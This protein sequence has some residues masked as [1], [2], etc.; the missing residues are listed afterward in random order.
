MP[1]P[2]SIAARPSILLAACALVL[3]VVFSAYP[4]HAQGEETLTSVA[5]AAASPGDKCP[6]ADTAPAPTAVEVE[7]VPIVVESTTN[8]YFVLYARPD[9]DSV[10]QL[11]VAVTLGQAGTTTLAESV[12]ALPKERYRVEKY[13]IANPADIDGDCIDDITELE[14]PTGMNPINPAVG[15]DF[16]EGVVGIPDQATFEALAY[17]KRWLKFILPDLEAERPIVYFVNSNTYHSHHLFLEAIGIGLDAP[18][19]RGHLDYNPDIVS[20]S[21][22]RGSYYFSL[23]FNPP[24]LTFSEVSR[25]YSLIAASMP[26]LD[27]N[28]YLY[29]PNK[30]LPY[31]Q[32]NLPLF[33]ESR[34]DLIFREDVYPGISFLPLNP[35]QGYGLLRALD[36]DER[37]NPRDVVIYE[38]L[39]NDLPRVAGIISVVPQTPLSHVN[40][41]AVQDGVPNAFIRGA[42]DK[43]D[44]DAL[45]GSYVHY[46]VDVDSYSLRAATR[47]EVDAHYAAS[48]PARAQTPRRDLSVTDITP[49]SD[50]E[51][52]DWT[53][54]GVKAANVAVLGTLGFP[55]GTVPDGFAVP[56]YF[57]DEFMKHNGFYDDI[58][59]M[60]ADP[61]FQTDYDTQEA[62]LKKLRKAIK[63]GDVPEWMTAALEEMHATYPEVQS[64]RYRSSTNNEDLPGFNGAGLYDSKT[65]HPDETVE[66]GIAKSLKQ[67]YASLWN[68]RAFTER[69]LHRIDH[70]AAAMGVLVHPNYTGELANGVAVSFDPIYNR[71]G[72]HYVNTQVG[73]DLVTNPDAH[74]VPEEILLLP[75]DTYVILATSNQ[76]EPGQ[77]LMS[78]AQL[79]QLRGH[80]EVIHDRF[81]ELYG[82]KAEE[83]FAMEIEFKITSDDV[84]AIKQARPWVFSDAGSQ[85]G[86]SLATGQPTIS[87][88]ARVGETLTASTE[89]ITDADGLDN[90]TF[91]YQWVR[92]D[93]YA[94]A[95]I[96]DAT[97]STYTLDDADAGQT[98]KVRVSFTDDAGHTETL[99][100]AA[101][102]TVPP[103]AN[104][105]ATGAPAISGTARVGETLTADVSGIED[106]DGL[107]D[108]TF[109]YQWLAGDVELPEATDASYTL[110]EA[111]EGK[112]IKVKVSFTDYWG[113][114][115]T[116]TS[117]ATE[118]AAAAR[119]NNSATGA[120]VISGT[121]HAGQTLMADTSGI[122]DADGLTNVTYDYQWVADDTDI[123]G[124]TDSTYTLAENDVG[125]TLK[126]R[127]SFTDNANNEETLTSAPT[128]AVEARLNT[129]ATGLPAING[130]VQVGETLTV[131][132]SAIA[133]AD[134]LD[135]AVF[136]YQW[137]AGGTDIE[138]ATGSSYTL[139]SSEEGEAIQVRVTYTD[140]VGNRETLTSAAMGT[141]EAAPPTI[142]VTPTIDSLTLDT[143]DPAEIGPPSYAL[144]TVAW[145]APADNGGS[146]ITS[147]DLRVFPRHI[148]SNLPDK[149]AAEWSVLEGIWDSGDLELTLTELVKGVNYEIQVRAVNTSGYGPWSAGARKTF[150]SAPGRIEVLPF[151]DDGAI[152]VTQ[153]KRVDDGG[154]SLT[155]YDVRYIRRD[156]P[157]KADANW[158]LLRNLEPNPIWK[159]LE[160][161]VS[162]L[163]NG[164]WY[165]L[166][167]R[168]VNAVG[169]GPWSETFEQRPAG[170][171]SAPVL[172]QVTGGNRTLTPGWR[173]PT[174][175]GGVGIV[176]YTWCY[177][178]SDAPDKLGRHWTCG[179]YA[180]YGFGPVIDDA[181]LTYT[182]TGLTNNMQYD[183][184][185]F[186]HGYYGDRSPASNM[187]SGTPL[188]T[189]GTP[190]ISG[191]AQVGET[192][193][194]DV[195]GIADADGLDNATFGHQWVS[196]DGSADADI[197]GATASTYTL[198]S[199]DGGKTIKVRVNFTDEAGHEETLTS[200]A[201]DTVAYVPGPP[202]APG[203][204]RIKAGDS[205][206]QVSWQAPAAENKAPVQRYRIQ[207]REEGGSSQEVHTALLTHTLSNLTNGVAYM[208]Q[209]AAEN[210]AG[211]GP[212]SAEMSAIPQAEVAT[213][214]D[215]PQGFSG[216]AVYHRRVSL[217]W[218]D[219]FGA[220]SYEVQFYDW[221]TRS[222]VVL[223]HEDITVAF[224]GSSAV[225]D[226]LTGTSLWWLRVRAVN[227]AGASEWTEM[228]QLIATKASDWETEE[229][230]SPATG[231][232]TISGTAQVGETLTADTSGI[233]DTEGL[234]KATFT[235]QWLADDTDIDGATAS[236]YTLTSS[237]EGKAIKVRVSFTDDADHEETMT[238]AATAVVTAV[239]NNPATGL[240]VV[241]GTAQV[242]QTLTADT[243]GIADADG[244][245][246]VSYSYQWIADDVEIAGATDASYTLSDDD[247]GNTIKVRVSFTDDAGN[248]ETLTSAATAA[249]AAKP[250]SPAT[251]AP[252]INGT[253]K[254]GKTLTADTSGIADEDGLDDVSY[255]YQWIAGG[256]DIDGASGSSHT[257]TTSEQ[258]QTI[259]VQVSFTDAQNNEETLT[260]AATAAVAGAATVPGEPEHLNVSPHDDQGLDLYWEAPARDGG[261]PVTGYKVQWKEAAG[262][263]D[264]PE[265]VSEETVTGTTHTINGLTEGVEHA[266]RVMASNEVGEGPASAEQTGI[267][268]ETGA[269]EKVRSR[270]DGATLRVLYDEALDEGSAPPADAFV[271]KVA[272][273]CEDTKWQDEK[274]RRAVDAVSVKGDTVVLT[275]ASAVMAEDYVVVSYTPPSDEASP[276]VQDTAGNPAAAIRPTQVFNDTEEANN[277]ATGAPAISGTAQVD[278]TLTADT[279][280]IADADGLDNATF[281]YQWIAGGTDI[282]GAT[283]STYT[284][285]SSEQGQTVQV[286]VTF[287]DNQGN[288]ETLTSAA[289]V[290][291]SP[292]PPLTASFG[293]KPSG[294]DGQT[295][296]TFEL[297]FSEEFGISYLTLRD[298]A[299]TVTDGEVTSAQRL[300]QG[301]NIGWTITVTPDSAAAVTVVLPVTTDCDAEGAICTADGRKLSN[302]LELTVSG[303]DS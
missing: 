293:S 191:T 225:V 252:T 153:G 39:P 10:R 61:D 201:T 23:N 278:E 2:S 3:A 195:S 275:L 146:V 144:L 196:N 156:A 266:V 131:D 245:D 132:T 268:R 45:I 6:G 170:N 214:P 81:A 274:A 182:I 297:R 150:A 112:A 294:H 117:P 198:V 262:S 68:F 30:Q 291:V 242:G 289:T 29:V 249:V 75:T 92:H 200:A 59:E 36:P 87:G 185:L 193:T 76:V 62:E 168:A 42:L 73:E 286:R 96:R 177:I 15:I 264:A 7:A 53:A 44:I 122:A 100:S 248:E 125:K 126:V 238:S 21:G 251:G 86:N 154:S 19:V 5:T 172:D 119:P 115:E 171:P 9:L 217:D 136:S 118:A 57:Y 160:Y 142:P 99:T 184:R 259:Q 247:E 31:I 299:F 70:L 235:Y 66:D 162:G 202:G 222:L 271:V 260:S 237:D 102:E 137:I 254:V 74:S 236:S 85:T 106:A 13:L 58:Q 180:G 174:S 120:P 213:N 52:D 226:Q 151:S 165:D 155:A 229:A 301:S 199:A 207:Y 232:P 206:L 33:R 281:S 224:S 127:V 84:L 157:D 205:A 178:R 218:G 231:V 223:P 56:F 186:A 302:R 77:L 296:F 27:D 43:T 159:T 34:I 295:A 270:V 14:D 285:T 113:T 105:P 97:T 188:K 139:A 257:L 24:R 133:D 253:V 215:T 80:L 72:R 230:N 183:V 181:Y 287:T 250:N 18:I 220:D 116:V 121:A 212:A 130:T 197:A 64:L 60:L 173:R 167:G 129:P 303:P 189:P 140:D 261:S 26:V 89:G 169:P 179:S 164:V 256:S 69:D 241:R 243:S 46:T 134:G 108:A 263:W 258:G 79:E 94:D 221:N 55:D 123:D 148:P 190:T 176:D 78:D 192:L 104:T 32:P 265:D 239:A 288:A 38:A 284:P 37:P 88:T 109:S 22:S 204:V 141:V 210:A 83:P 244:L 114:E 17:N 49:L 163:A 233:A 255:S 246:D 298:H 98:I 283:G 4:V 187:L 63:K 20:P 273:R 40:L 143:R 65:Q 211:Y 290:A 282:A 272:C 279:S 161:T 8:E 25:A 82:I 101:T 128:A 124:A 1:T 277:P 67:V 54:F 194:A 16:S 175:D 111:D 227:A 292:R 145:S 138:G 276:R 35:G 166:Q 147:Y 152:T 90:A 47:A 158:T 203:E 110:S 41:R 135:D 95:D 91:S 103:A 228:V 48:R 107:D 11:P 269:P 219:V 50:I 234:D 216:K 267:P 209:V 93:G 51:F 71:D 208:V 28:V 149:P 12:E 240:P 280:G 300:T